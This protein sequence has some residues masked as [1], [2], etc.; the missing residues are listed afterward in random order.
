MNN[1][2]DLKTPCF[3]INEYKLQNNISA[4]IKA[5][6]NTFNKGIVGYSVKTNSLPFVLKKALEFGC[7]A[8]VV[9]ADEFLLAKR[10][11]FP[12][13]K[14]IYNGPMKSKETFIEAVEGGAIVNIENFREIEW[15]KDINNQSTYNLGVRVNI[16]FNLIGVDEEPHSYSRFGFSYENG[17]VARAVNT[18]NKYGFTVNGLHAHRTSTTRKILIYNKIAK[19]VS[20]IIKVL[21]LDLKYIDFG[22]GYFGD[23]PGKPSYYDYANEIKKTLSFNTDNLTV[24][25]E[26]GNGLIASPVDYIFSILDTKEIHG[27]VVCSSD[28]TRLDVDPFFH[29]E[30][31]NHELLGNN[32]LQVKEECQII[33][34]ATCLENDIL[35]ELYNDRKLY[36]GDKIVLKC[37][38]AYTMA[39]TPNFI[40][41]LPIVY[42]TN[43]GCNFKV[44][45]DKWQPDIIMMNSKLE[46]CYE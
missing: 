15:L 16:N 17:D 22:G 36:A 21:K 26:P 7:Y 5:L 18:I 33:T 39:L 23:M 11:G 8:E 40:N 45:R 1:I 20:D 9:S 27:K 4:F 12:V 32:I 14:I 24:I 38:G 37:V 44:V 10:I 35:F 6:N 3:I 34:G 46:D 42:K 31:Y 29:K 19:Y 41:Y 43:D 13:S 28:A 2:M 30:S 25:V